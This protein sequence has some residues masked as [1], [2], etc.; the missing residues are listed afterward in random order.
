MGIPQKTRDAP[1]NGMELDMPQVLN[2][3]HT[4]RQVPVNKIKTSAYIGRP[5]KWGNPFAIGKEHGNRAQVV[6]KY[7]KWLMAQPEL[8][9]QVK[10]ELKGKDLYCFCAPRACHGDVLLRVANS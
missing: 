5:S 4:G 3:Q 6:A 7:E 8:V 10:A 2:I 1:H 9:A